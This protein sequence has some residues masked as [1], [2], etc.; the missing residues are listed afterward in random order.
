MWCRP[1]DARSRAD[2]DAVPDYCNDAGAGEPRIASS[3]TRPRR[4]QWFFGVHHGEE[5]CPVSRTVTVVEFQSAST[6]I[7]PKNE[8]R[9]W[10]V[11]S[12]RFQS[13][14][15]FITPKNVAQPSAGR[16]CVLVSIRFD[17]H[18]AEELADLDDDE[19]TAGFQSA[20]T[21]ITPK[22]TD[23]GMKL[24][25]ELEFQSA[26]TFITPKNA[27]RDAARRRGRGVS[28]RFDVH[29]AEE[30]LCDGALRA[31]EE[32]QSASTFITPKNAVGRATARERGRVSI[33]FDVHHAEEPR[34]GRCPA[35][36]PPA[37]R[38]FNPLRRSSRR[39]TSTSAATPRTRTCFNP[40]R[41]SS[42]RRT[43][44]DP[45]RHPRWQVS[46]RFDV[47]H[48][49][50][51]HAVI[52]AATSGMFQ[53]ASTFITPKN[54][55][56][57]VTLPA[58][59]KFQ[60]ASTF[61]TPKNAGRGR[62][63]PGWRFQSASTFIT[64]KNPPA[65]SRPTRPSG[66]NPLRRSSRRRTAARVSPRTD[67]LR[68]QSASTFITPKNDALPP[69]NLLLVEFQSASTFITPKN[70][71]QAEARDGCAVSIRFDV[72]HAEERCA[73]S[74]PNVSI[75]FGDRFQSASTFITPKNGEEDRRRPA[76]EV[77]IRFDVHHAEERR[78]R[79]E[80]T[81]GGSFNPLRR[82][83]RR[84]T[85]W[86][87]RGVVVDLMFQSASTFITPKNTPPSRC[88]APV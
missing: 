9:A 63:G 38:S 7:T 34:A 46:I 86:R 44:L 15:T 22:N 51:R 68:F 37:S 28:I 67:G 17:V 74:S 43:V 12:P 57:M 2:P 59:W 84:R 41:R 10:V 50:E 77:S 30:P 64:P 39:R 79:T 69:K 25:P 75:G 88:P 16:R 13:A 72:H 29:H 71:A 21:F 20:S 33:R 56:S 54:R 26:S 45:A 32:F 49:E 47:H 55:G 14:S 23:V 81:G 27:V 40:L 8:W 80:R 42:R 35:R 19:P 85:H 83:S 53:S 52:Q 3:R 5:R 36:A 65:W 82:S 66:F 6:F 60:S 58:G 76:R 70:T 1:A 61:I 24:S 87:K 78:A 18:H 62:A 31:A 48:A 73:A 11:T 4:F